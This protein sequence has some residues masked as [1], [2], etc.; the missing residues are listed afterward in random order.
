MAH[1]AQPA[2][3][4]A[5]REGDIGLRPAPRP[6]IFVAVE[7]RRSHPVLQRQVKTVLDAEP[8]LFGAVDQEQSA[9]RPEGLAA[10]ALL[11]L[12]VDHDDALAGIGDFGRG[13]QARQPA[14]DHNYVRIVSHCVFPDSPND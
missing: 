14:A 7:T 8:A 13:D 10:E 4:F 5:G 1:G 9:E 6:E 2:A 11:A 3:L 12:L